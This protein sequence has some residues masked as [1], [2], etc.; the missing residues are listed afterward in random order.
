MLQIPENWQDISSQ[1]EGR[2]TFINGQNVF[3]V[4]VARYDGGELPNPSR[5]DLVALASGFLGT[6]GRTEILH[7]DSGKCE[8]GSFGTVQYYSEDLEHCQVWHLSNGKDFV[9]A[10]YL[11]S[12]SLRVGEIDEVERVV[13]TISLLSRQLES[14]GTE[15]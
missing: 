6:G 2:T 9:M 13:R 5:E 3:Q 15:K 8:L 10:T 12:E 7:A 4:S 1:N 14:G 11:C